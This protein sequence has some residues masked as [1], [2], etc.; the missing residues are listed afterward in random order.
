MLIPVRIQKHSSQHVSI[1][2]VDKITLSIDCVDLEVG[3]FSDSKNHFPVWVGSKRHSIQ[4][5]D[6]SQRFLGKPVMQNRWMTGTSS[7]TMSRQIQLHANKSAFKISATDK[8]TVGCR[9]RH[10]AHQKHTTLSP[11][12]RCERILVQ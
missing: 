5:V 2:F 6:V 10:T 12:W 9:Y 4:A 1:S 3:V 7:Q 8:Y 11:H